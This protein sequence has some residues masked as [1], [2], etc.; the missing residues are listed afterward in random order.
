[1]KYI[2]YPMDKIVVTQSFGAR[3]EVYKQFGLKGHNGTDFRTRFLDSPLG[4]RYVSACEDGVVEEVRW[5]TR[6]FGV[7]V[8]IR[9]E[10]KALSIYRHFTKP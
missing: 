9:Q 2:Y 10:D 1:M 7:Q 4:K 3:P 8:L 5:D 6:G